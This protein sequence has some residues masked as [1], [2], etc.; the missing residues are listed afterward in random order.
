LVH[1]YLFNVR[2]I[3]SHNYFVLAFYYLAYTFFKCAHCF[4]FGAQIILSD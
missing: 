4:L 2:I 1:V 3:S